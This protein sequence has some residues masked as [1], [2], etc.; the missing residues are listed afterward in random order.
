[1][2]GP[3]A[4]ARDWLSDTGL[5]QPPG[6]RSDDE[7]RSASWLELFFDL[8][9]VLVV[10]ELAGALAKDLTWTGGLT[11]AGL[12]TVTWWSWASSTLY[13]N[14]FDTDDLVYRLFKLAGMLA[15]IGMAAAAAEATTKYAV[16]FAGAYV[17]LRLLLLAQYARAHRAVPEARGIVRLYMIGAGA[18]AALWAA[19]MLVPAPLRYGL[20]AAG[21][22]VDVLVPFAATFAS[23]SVRLHLEHLPER[24]G[25]F[26]ILVL[27]ESVAAVAHGV[28]DES[29][30]GEAIVAGV[31]AFVLA[32]GLWWVCFDL[33]GASAKKLLL[34]HGGAGRVA[35]DIYFYGHLP[36]ALGLASIGVGLEQ[37][38]LETAEEDTRAATRLI[39]CG[40]VALVLVAVS[41]TNAAM[42][43]NWRSG[44]WWPALAAVLAVADALLDLPALPVVGALGLLVVAVAATGTV[45]QA[46]GRVEVAAM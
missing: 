30:T 29:W 3:L 8:A 17:A 13:A 14:R 46:R 18:G 15:V 33:A 20:W 28:H 39:L 35:T 25:L 4:Q 43:R 27:G 11:F 2:P 24:L 21:L 7:G 37:L 36:L 9:F 44:W 23:G 34:E 16:H 41:A 45:Q 31:M 5:L 19:S 40:G 38:I 42:S 6:L 22:L 12:F 1:M 32:A 26:L 10:A